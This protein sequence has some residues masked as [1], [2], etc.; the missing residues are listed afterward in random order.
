MTTHIKRFSEMA[1]RKVAV[2]AKDTDEIKEI[3]LSG[4]AI[5]YNGKEFLISVEKKKSASHSSRPH[6]PEFAPLYANNGDFEAALEELR[7]D[8]I[9]IQDDDMGFEGWHLYRAITPTV[10]FRYDTEHN[11]VIAVF[12]EEG[13]LEG[14]YTCYAHIGQHSVCSREWIE[15]NTVPATPSQYKPLLRELETQGYKKLNI[16][17]NIFKS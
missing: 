17:D 4:R 10:M 5:R 13:D 3:L 1:A 7:G 8:G 6:L 2:Y 14:N 15:E 12:D 11:E 9:E 16:V